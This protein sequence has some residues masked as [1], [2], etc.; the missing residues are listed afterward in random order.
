MG[1]DLLHSRVKIVHCTVCGTETKGIFD[2]M[3]DSCRREREAEQYERY[4]KKQM[5]GKKGAE[6][7]DEIIVKEGMDAWVFRGDVMCIECSKPLMNY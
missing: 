3:C 2:K 1:K 7:K 6:K 4:L 5:A